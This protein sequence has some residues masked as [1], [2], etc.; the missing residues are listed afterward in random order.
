[1]RIAVFCPGRVVGPEMFLRPC[2][3]EW[4]SI[5][6]KGFT[7]GYSRPP[8]RG[9]RT[10]PCGHTFLEDGIDCVPVLSESSYGEAF[11]VLARQLME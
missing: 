1:M 9:E 11:A 2:R 8:L 3:G 4:D 7:R 6:P 5:A 10:R